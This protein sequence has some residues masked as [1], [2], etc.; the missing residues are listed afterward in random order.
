MADVV[1]IAQQQQHLLIMFFREAAVAIIH[2][3]T[4]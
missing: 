4:L 1:S 3:I 2:G